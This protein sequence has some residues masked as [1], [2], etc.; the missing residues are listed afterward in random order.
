METELKEKKRKREPDRSK[1]K[2]RERKRESCNDEKNEERTAG[3]FHIVSELRRRKL[4]NRYIDRN[5]A[6]INNVYITMHS[7]M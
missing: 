1:E 3:R 7:I 6:F 2:E 5:A 4:H